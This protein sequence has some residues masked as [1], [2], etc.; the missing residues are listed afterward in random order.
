MIAAGIDHLDPVSDR[1]WDRRYRTR[2]AYGTCRYRGGGAAPAGGAGRADGGA[3]RAP[4][5]VSRI[6][7][8]ISA[9]KFSTKEVN[10]G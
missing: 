2:L 4:M 7:L 5:R 6:F 9:T 3:H 10:L 8:A 1:G